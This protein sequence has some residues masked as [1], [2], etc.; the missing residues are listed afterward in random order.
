MPDEVSDD[1][2]AL[3]EPLSVGVWANQKAGVGAGSRVL[4]A[5]AGP[6][7]LIA[8]QVALAF[9]A[10][11]VVI[12]DISPERLAVAESIGAIGVEAG[13]DLGANYDAFLECSGAQAAMT[14]GIGATARAGHVVLVGLGPAE[15]RVSLDAIQQRELTVTGTFR[16]ANTWPLALGLVSRSEVDL[17]RLVTHHYPLAEAAIPLRPIDRTQIKAMVHSNWS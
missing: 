15:I 4:I 9:G 6:I 16:Y 14:A 11:E 8:A 7:G 13:G 1:A 12:S 3:L 17:D 5:G 2:A 10:E